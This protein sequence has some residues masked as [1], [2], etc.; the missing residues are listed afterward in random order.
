MATDK[1]ERVGVAVIREVC[2]HIF[3]LMHIAVAP[4]YQQ[5]GYGS[6]ILN[7]LLQLLNERHALKLEVGTG[8]FGY[9]LKF[10]QRHGFRVTAI[11]KDFFPE[12]Y[13]QP[14]IE[15]GPQYKDMLMLNF[16]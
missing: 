12:H 9:A 5:Q 6:N 7:T 10:Y 2:N 8:A 11:R 1:G 16:I 3:K 13:T 14:L 15:E 4:Q